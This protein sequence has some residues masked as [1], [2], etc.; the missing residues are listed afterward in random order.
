MFLNQVKNELFKVP[1]TNLR[2]YNF[3]SN[4]WK[5]MRSLADDRSI[6]I[7]K[8]DKGSSIV[9]WDRLDYLLEDKK[10][11]EDFKIYKNILKVIM[12]W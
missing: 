3:T 1:E 4:E 10:Q 8:A 11:L 2:Y 12:K 5:A 6:I 9:V 7:K